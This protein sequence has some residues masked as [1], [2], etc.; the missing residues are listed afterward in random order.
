M[1]ILFCLRQE[2]AVPKT[3]AFNLDWMLESLGE[4]SIKIPHALAWTNEI[5]IS[6]P[7]L[8]ASVGFKAFQVILTC[9]KI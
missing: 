7:R 4:L 5:R 9:K 3:G 8:Q 2:R 6:G 1:R